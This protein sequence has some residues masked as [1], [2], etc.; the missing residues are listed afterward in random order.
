[1]KRILINLITFLNLILLGCSSVSLDEDSKNLI[2]NFYINLKNQNPQH[3]LQYFSNEY[4]KVTSPEQTMKLFD[5]LNKN[6]GDVLEWQMKD[7]FVTNSIGTTSGKRISI[8]YEVKRTKGMA[9]DSFNIFKEGGSS[10]Y[11]IDGY[12]SE[13]KLPLE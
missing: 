8:K 10:S 12:H 4:N 9:E 3:N 13:L 2:N 7:Y 11:K 5:L 6:A 1:M